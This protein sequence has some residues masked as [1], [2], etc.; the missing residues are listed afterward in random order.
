[1]NNIQQMKKI[2]IFEENRV[3]EITTTIREIETGYI[4]LNDY[5]KK[6]E[7]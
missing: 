3:I 6:G 4:N 7:I 2:T 1:M 5:Y